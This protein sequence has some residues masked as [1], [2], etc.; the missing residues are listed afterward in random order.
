MRV[1][2]KAEYACVAMLELAANFSDAAPLRITGHRSI[3]SGGLFIFAPQKGR[4]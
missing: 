4:H 3:R 1:S 2:A